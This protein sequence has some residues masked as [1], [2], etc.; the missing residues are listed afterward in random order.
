MR[1]QNRASEEQDSFF[2]QIPR[3][4]KRRYAVESYPAETENCK[5]FRDFSLTNRAACTDIAPSSHEPQIQI[6]STHNARGEEDC[7]WGH[8]G[9]P[10]KHGHSHRHRHQAS[11][12]T[13]SYSDGDPPP[14]FREPSPL[15]VCPLPLKFGIH[16]KFDLHLKRDIALK[17]GCEKNNCGLREGISG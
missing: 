2:S 4:S 14:C 16:L 6:T 11:R 9:N 12:S 3:Y 17:R 7:D 10:C 5:I 8:E 13:S 1:Q 15:P